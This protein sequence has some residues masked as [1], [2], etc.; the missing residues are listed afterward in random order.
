MGGDG[1]ALNHN[2]TQPRN[3]GAAPGEK[4]EGGAIVLVLTKIERGIRT[5]CFFIEGIGLEIGRVG[6]GLDD[7]HILVVPLQ[8]S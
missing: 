4:A 1:I 6:I 5:A 3:L 7:P 8:G 2:F